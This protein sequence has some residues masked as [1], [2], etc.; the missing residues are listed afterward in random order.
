MH[1][2]ADLG[3]GPDRGPAVDH[4]SLIH[5]GADVHKRRHQHHALGD[6]G[7]P[8]HDGSRHRAK[9]G[10]PPAVFTP[11]LKLAGHFVPPDRFAGATVDD[12]HVIQ[13]KRQQ[14]RL[15]GPLIDVPVAVLARL[16]H[17]QG[18]AVKCCQR[19]LYRRTDLTGC[20]WRNTVP[21][22]PGGFDCGF[23]VRIWHGFG[24]YILTGLRW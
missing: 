21:G 12:C 2:L 6:I 20:G 18:A 1:I 9:P 17:A 13:T 23:K 7:R 4:R 22:L 3:A 24:P 19:F 8:A 14:H 5:I 15:F 10:V 11:A 16:G